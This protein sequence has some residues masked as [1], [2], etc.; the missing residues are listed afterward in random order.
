MSDDTPARSAP[1]FNSIIETLVRDRVSHHLHEAV[2]KKMVTAAL[3]RAALKL[4]EKV[5][6]EAVHVRLTA[7]VDAAF[8]KFETEGGDVGGGVAAAL[9]AALD[10]EIRDRMIHDP[11]LAKIIRDEA[12]A[13]VRRRVRGM[14]FGEPETKGAASDG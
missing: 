10:G 4:I 9:R 1:D 6:G 3:D 7:A 14:L 13:E 5:C 8:R 12:D 2:I 11:V